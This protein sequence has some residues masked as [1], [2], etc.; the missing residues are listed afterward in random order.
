MAGRG[1]DP[2]VDNVLAVAAFRQRSRHS[3]TSTDHRA[4]STARVRSP[5]VHRTPRRA[6]S[7]WPMT[8]WAQS[9]T[10][11]SRFPRPLEAFR[12][13]APRNAD[14][15]R[16][17][18]AGTLGPRHPAR[19]GGCGGTRFAGAPRRA[20]RAG[21]PAGLGNFRPRRHPPAG[22]HTVVEFSCA[23]RIPSPGVSSRLSRSPAWR[24]TCAR[25]DM[26]TVRA[27][28]SSRPLESWLAGTGEQGVGLR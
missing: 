5:A 26:T 6:S 20:P 7:T 9:T 3:P 12:S 28:A 18:R 2:R 25:L 27:S 15:G 22:Q 11:P 4:A 1:D 16:G 10:S 19:G 8:P 14:G 21:D 24:R 17:W 23:A 13:R